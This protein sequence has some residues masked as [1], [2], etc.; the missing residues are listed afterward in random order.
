[1]KEF[2][3]KAISYVWK[4]KII[5]LIVLVALIFIGKSVYSKF[6]NTSGQT[7]Y[8]TTQ[9]VKGTVVS[10]VSGTGQVSSS[11]QLTLYPKASGQITYVGV[12]DGQ[13]VTAGTV[14]LQIDDTTAQ[15][16]LRDAQINLQSQQ[17]SMQQSDLQNSNDNLTAALNSAYDSGFSTIS[18]TF[19]DLPSTMN[20]LYNMLNNQ[21]L[22]NNTVGL[23][24]GSVAQI[25][26]NTATSAYYAAKNA[27]DK[28][29]IDF[30][31]LNRNSPQ[32]QI[33][34]VLNETYNTTSLVTDTINDT[35]TLV[36]YMIKESNNQSTYT[37]DQNTLS[38]YTSNMNTHL[39]ALSSAQTSIK[40]ASDAL[41]NAGFNNQNSQLSLQQKQ[42]ALA[43]AQAN[44]ANYTLVAPFDGVIT[45]LNVQQYDSASSGTSVATLITNNEYADITLNEV[46]VAKVATGQPATI[47]FGAVPG[48]SIAGTV[49]AINE[50]G[51]VSQGVVSYDVKV[52]FDTQDD[53]VKPSM[54]ASVNI[55]TNTASY[56]LVVPNS[57]VKTSKGTSYVQVF[58][59]LPPG[60]SSAGATGFVSTTPPENIIVQTGAS[61]DTNTVIV[62]GIKEGDEVVSRTIASSTTSTS[63]SAPSLF[64]N[65]RGGVRTGGGAVFRATGG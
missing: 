1:M 42:N 31:A 54:S 48:L 51:T 18:S 11:N 61:D 28:V 35:T 19:L 27:L 32:S 53:R 30:A 15:Q 49:Q 55:I 4:H 37:S 16:A 41:Q 50:V 29:Q 20:G 45:N 33:D 34:T 24:G 17:V 13:K 12:T 26:R 44:L 52:G 56:V 58:R 64:G 59:T 2:F 22:S 8:V 43:D 5:S 60:A 21:N 38:T 62:S 7:R 23:S 40:S 3:S 46:D 10:Y 47:T 36:T 39:S 63:S 14:I 57:A 6:T 65:T 9:A 25:Y